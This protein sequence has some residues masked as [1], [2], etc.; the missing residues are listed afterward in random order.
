MSRMPPYWAVA[1]TE[2]N[3][4]AFACA[5]ATAAGFVVFAPKVRTRVA[6]AWRVTPLFPSYLFVQI[7]DQWHVLAR[8][9]GIARVV[10]FG[11]TPAR[12]PDAEINKLMARADANGVIVLPRKPRFVL[13]DK[14]RVTGGPLNGLDGLYAGM[15]AKERAAVLIQ[16]LGSQRRV[17][18]PWACWRRRCSVRPGRGLWT[19]PA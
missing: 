3:R 5:M 16:M 14:V 10:K 4:D 13:G 6:K 2:V 17:E 7:V 1:R 18:V 12:C 8:T 19:R 15:G 9:F 11:D